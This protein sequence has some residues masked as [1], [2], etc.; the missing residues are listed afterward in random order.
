[1]TI[2]K[3]VR[4][5][6]WWLPAVLLAPQVLVIAVFCVWAGGQ[7]LGN[8]CFNQR[9]PEVI[10]A[11]TVAGRRDN[12]AGAEQLLPFILAVGALPL[13]ALVCLG[14]HGHNI[15]A[16]GAGKGRQIFVELLGFKSA[17]EQQGQGLEACAFHQIPLKQARP[18]FALRMACAG[19]AVTRQ[20]N[21][22]KV[23]GCHAVIIH[24][25]GFAGRGADFCQFFAASQRVDKR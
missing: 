20:V 13:A 24:R 16:V 2:E 25:A 5:K 4:F 11:V 15:Q 9:A 19:I 14:Q 8:R 18:F 22:I 12:G 21:E 3:R 17:V 23:M 1:M 7:A 6:S 10:N